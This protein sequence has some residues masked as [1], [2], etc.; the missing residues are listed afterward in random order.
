MRNRVGLILLGILFLLIGVSILLCVKLRT[1]GFGAREKPM[2]VE[3]WIARRLRSLAT[4]ASIKSQKNPIS[5]TPLVIAE[6]RDHYADHCAFCHGNTGDGK[7]M[8][9]EGMFPPP[10]NLKD[11]ET[12]NLSDG[13]LF[14]II[15]DGIRFTGMPGF[16]G[17]DEDNWKL[18]AFIRHL[19]KLSEN[20][21]SYMKE[22][23]QIED[24]SGAK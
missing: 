23:N 20:E 8:Y 16:G 1:H 11:P 7:T 10:P 17:G 24:S 5:I 19:P 22:I 4:K 6:A 18:V 14:N 13:E 9:G 3:I 2:K 12:Q 21:V 15:K